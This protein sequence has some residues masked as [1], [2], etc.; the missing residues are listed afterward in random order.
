MI[1]EASAIV[2]RNALQSQR[3][4]TGMCVREA[5]GAREGSEVALHAKCVKSVAG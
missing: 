5:K 4:G 1:A 3:M 2:P